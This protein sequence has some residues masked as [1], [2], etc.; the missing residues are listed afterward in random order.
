MKTFKNK[1]MLDKIRQNKTKRKLDYKTKKKFIHRVLSEW[2]KQTNGGYIK[3]DTYSQYAHDYYL[4]LDKYPN[5]NIHVHF[6]LH[7]FRENHNTKNNIEY[8]FKKY[9]KHSN[10]VC[11]DIL[12]DDPKKVV[13]GMIKKFQK[14]LDK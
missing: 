11:I 5:N 1:K 8:L 14:F 4:S 6:G 10:A 9:N 3:L 7:H 2:K 13:A 12:K